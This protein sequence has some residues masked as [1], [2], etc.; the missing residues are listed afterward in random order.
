MFRRKKKQRTKREGRGG[1]EKRNEGT[2][3]L[4]KENNILTKQTQQ[5]KEHH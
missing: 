2:D 4:I 5:T 3:R 1:V